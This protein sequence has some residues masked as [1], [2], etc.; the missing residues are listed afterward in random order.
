[1]TYTDEGFFYCHKCGENRRHLVTKALT[2][3]KTRI[4]TVTECDCGVTNESFRDAFVEIEFFKVLDILANI[5]NDL[6]IH[7][8]D[9]GLLFDAIKK[10][11]EDFV[12]SININRR[13]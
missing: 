6:V 11:E 13:R 12:K 7:V 5:R 10:A 9:K 4:K 2:E 8:D 1:M 3:Q